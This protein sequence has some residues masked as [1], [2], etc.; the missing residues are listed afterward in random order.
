MTRI[1]CNMLSN[2]KNAQLSKKKIMFQKKSN[3]CLKIL[4]I[5]WDE[6]FILG[7]KI[8]KSNPVILKIFLKYTNKIP[9]INSL[10]LLTK[11][12]SK[13]YYSSKQIWKVNLT[14]GLV[15]VSTNMG[16]LTISECKKLKIG[17]EPCVII[18]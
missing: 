3:L 2:I 8:C 13:V 1:L 18:K 10:M 14:N 6:G 11:P 12:G 17:G 9:A 16:F 4:N 5:L 15:I 7:Y